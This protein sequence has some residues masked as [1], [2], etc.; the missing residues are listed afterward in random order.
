M[1]KPGA[2]VLYIPD[3]AEQL[4]QTPL[5]VRRLIERRVLPSRRLGKRV[6]VLAEEWEKF[7][8]ALPVGARSRS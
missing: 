6:V 4:N 1:T 3:I 7:L 5:A 2:R 8:K